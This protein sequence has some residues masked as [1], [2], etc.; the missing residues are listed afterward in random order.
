MQIRICNLVVKQKQIYDRHDLFKGFP[1]CI[2]AGFHT[3]VD[4]RDFPDQ[5]Q[6]EGYIQH[7]LPSAECN[8]PTLF[9]YREIATILEDPISNLL[10]G[11]PLTN[12]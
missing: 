3:Y 9:R 8:T 12:E 11:H 7:R 6:D 10:C 1:A 2:P 4:S 5:L